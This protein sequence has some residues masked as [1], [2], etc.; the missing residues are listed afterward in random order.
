MPPLTGIRVLDLT[1]VLSGPFCAMLLGDLG[2]DV[3]KVEAPEGDLLRNTG[4]K[5]DGLSWYF[6]SFNRN[7]RSLRLDLR[8]PEGREVLAKLIQRADVLMENFRPGV[9]ARL[10]FDEARLR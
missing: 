8:K 10:G 6:A 5:R 2:A 4:A 3:L 7:K 9:L 1:R